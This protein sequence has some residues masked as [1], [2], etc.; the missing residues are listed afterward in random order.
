MNERVNKNAKV[1]KRTANTNQQTNDSV[2][3]CHSG[4]FA[5]HQPASFDWLTERERLRE[6]NAWLI[7]LGSFIDKCDDKIK[8]RLPNCMKSHTVCLCGPFRIGWQIC[9]NNHILSAL[10]AKSLFSSLARIFVP[11]SFCMAHFIMLVC[12]AGWLVSWSVRSHQ[13]TSASRCS[14]CVT[15]LQL[16][17]SPAL[18]SQYEIIAI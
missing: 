10:W 3:L 14:F 6:R 5:I 7:C 12:S 4:A 11:L 16:A 18:K 2:Y 9:D 15:V 13:W 8:C 17:S 1:T